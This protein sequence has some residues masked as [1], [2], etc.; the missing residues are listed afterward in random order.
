MKKENFPIKGLGEQRSVIYSLDG[1]QEMV[2]SHNTVI[3]RLSTIK[4]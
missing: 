1:H 3:L 4:H 2:L